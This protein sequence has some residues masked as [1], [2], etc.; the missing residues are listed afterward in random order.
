MARILID[1]P[2]RFVKQ[3]SLLEQHGRVVFVHPSQRP[4][5][6]STTPNRRLPKVVTNWG[7]NSPK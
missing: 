5:A 6:K 2:K 1:A 4:G 7:G 3:P